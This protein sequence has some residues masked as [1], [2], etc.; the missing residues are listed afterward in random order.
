MSA[1]VCSSALLLKI[2]PSQI[3]FFLNEGL[4]KETHSRMSQIIFYFIFIL[5]WKC[6]LECHLN[7]S[8]EGLQAVSKFHLMSL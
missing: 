7:K 8:A 4:N 3:K 6:V 5:K 1:M 2:F